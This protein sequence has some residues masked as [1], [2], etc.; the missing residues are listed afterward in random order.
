L[1]NT[2]LLLLA[3][4]TIATAMWSLIALLSHFDLYFFS[5]LVFYL[6]FAL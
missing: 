3:V 4:T 6:Y 5:L 2:L 1:F